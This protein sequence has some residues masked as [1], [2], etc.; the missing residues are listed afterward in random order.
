MLNKSQLGTSHFVT[1]GAGFIGSHLIDRLL[2]TADYRLSTNKVTVYDN[3]SSGKRENIEHQIG[4]DGF[5][6]VQADLL[7]M[8]ALKEAMQGHEIVWHLGAN[9]DIPGGNKITDLDL[10]NCTIAT[11]DV[12]EAMRQLGI[13]KILFASSACVY[14]DA[15]SIALDE[16]YGPLL[17]INLY[18]AGKLACEGLI[19]AYCHLFGIKAWIF[20]F[21]NVVGAEMGH[22]VIYDFIQKLKRNPK[23]LE[24]LGDGNQEKP[25]FLVE[26]CIDG[27]LRAF[28]NSNNQYDVYNLGCESFTKVTRVAQIVV[29]E[30]GLNNVK[31][32]YT[33]GKRGW[34]GDVPIVHFSVEKMK[35]L[36]WKAS[37]TSDEAVRIT[38]R[39]LLGIE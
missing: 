10:K 15:P 33:G 3:L 36:G 16:T 9:T 38:A 30:M 34:P 28:H 5:N 18:G 12:L 14:G 11:Y 6:F 2:S 21:G 17:P 39:R 20:R 32:K 37:H 22:G 26:D 35:K 24:T 31:F 19:S 25:F 1:G 27:M 8:K 7:D 29:E 23:E 13:E 4:K